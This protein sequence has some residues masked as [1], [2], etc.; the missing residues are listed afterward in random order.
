MACRHLVTQQLLAVPK[1]EGAA[2][3]GAR[4]GRAVNAALMLLQVLGQAEGGVT[5]GAFDERGAVFEE[6]L[7]Q[8]FLALVRISAFGAAPGMTRLMCFHVLS[9]P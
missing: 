6:M 1:G 3:S 2:A 8:I 5:L 4:L 7:I 9:M